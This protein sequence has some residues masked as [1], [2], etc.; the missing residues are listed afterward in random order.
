MTDLVVMV[1]TRGRR[2]QCERLLGSFRETASPGTDIA[3]ILDPDDEGTYDGADWGDALRAVLAPRGTLADK[4][5]QVAGAMTGTYPALMWCGDDHVFGT[6]G[7]DKLMLAALEDMGGHGWIYP[8]TVRRRDVPEIWMCS[9]SVTEALG[10]FF[11]PFLAQ[12]YGDNAIGELAKRAGLIRGCPEAK[13]EHLHYSVR[14]ETEHDATYREAEDAHGT[15]DLAAFR[16]WQADVL[17][18]E[19]S[20]LRRRFNTDVEWV[21]SRI[22]ARDPEGARCPA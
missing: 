12:Y 15:A 20:R 19:V 18:Y 6:P 21:I 10:W 9:S 14:K 11:P 8:D 1:P 3:V 5:N 7:W 22:S 17:P 16:R 2:A 13:A 4:L